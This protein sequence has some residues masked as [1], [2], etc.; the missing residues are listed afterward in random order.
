MIVNAGIKKILT[1]I[2]IV[3]ILLYPVAIYAGMYHI[4]PRYLALGFLVIFTLRLGFMKPISATTQMPLVLAG[5]G[6]IIIC[7]SSIGFNRPWMLQL[8]PVCVNMLLLLVFAYSLLYPPTLIERIARLTEKNL[9]PTAIHYTRKVTWVWCG[10]FMSNGLISLATTLYGSMKLW[11]LYNGFIA[12]ILM[13][14]LFLIELVIRGRVKKR[15][16]HA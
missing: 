12:Y 4:S 5:L 3:L 6:G 10:F 14:T 8:Y 1:L 13:G 16:Q 15:E 11:A 7:I 2:T 9:S